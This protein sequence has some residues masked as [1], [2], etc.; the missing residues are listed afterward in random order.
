MSEYT[1]LIV[2]DVEGQPYPQPSTEV[3]S[4]P[5]PAI[6][7][8]IADGALDADW[9][10]PDA[11]DS[12]NF[13]LGVHDGRQPRSYLLA[14]GIYTLG[15]DASNAIPISNR[16]VSRRHAYLIRVPH[17][18][19]GA[20]GFTYCLVDG[21]RQGGSSTNGVLVN[22]ERVATHYLK[23]GDLIQIG[24]EVRAYFFAL[25]SPQPIQF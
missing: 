10:S 16:F 17:R 13:T 25:V 11:G 23:S 2:P 5:L 1:E 19:A 24:P 21:N 7:P 9:L 4:G 15:R 22:G 8:A 3:A 20:M 18:S 14:Q 6:P 12:P